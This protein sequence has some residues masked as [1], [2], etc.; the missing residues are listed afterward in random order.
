MAN[1]KLD[2]R[3]IEQRRKR[4]IQAARETLSTKGYEGTTMISIAK[5]AGY[6][7]M[8]LYS[9]FNSKEELYLMVL[10]DIL[11]DLWAEL[12]PILHSNGSPSSILRQYAHRY[13][14]FYAQHP[15]LFEISMYWYRNR[16]HEDNIRLEVRDQFYKSDHIRADAL[17]SVYKQAQVQ[18]MLYGDM[19]IH[20]LK[21]I[22]SLTLDTLISEIVSLQYEPESLYT[23]YVN[24]YI[25]SIFKG[26]H[27]E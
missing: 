27:D 10:D 24:H 4:I 18:N 2:S 14:R 15:H 5:A 12:F 7:K 20:M 25:Q 23:G 11:S 21:K 26:D 16:I 3:H 13:Y 22:F 19:S 1:K 6:T 17:L 8:T 9:Y